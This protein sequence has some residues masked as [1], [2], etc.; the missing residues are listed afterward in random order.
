MKDA[1]CFEFLPEVVVD[2]SSLDFSD[3]R[4]LGGKIFGRIKK[5]SGFV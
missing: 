5:T 4:N 3:V 1:K 2:F